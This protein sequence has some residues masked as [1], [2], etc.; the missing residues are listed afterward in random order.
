M[1]W[2]T[3]MCDAGHSAKRDD[4]GRNGIEVEPAEVG[5]GNVSNT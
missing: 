4:A 3:G 2:I 5:G 1:M